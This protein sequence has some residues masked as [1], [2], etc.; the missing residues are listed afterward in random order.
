[1][2]A[3]FPPSPRDGCANSILLPSRS[4]PRAKSKLLMYV[5]AVL[6]LYD[7][8]LVAVGRCDSQC[9]WGSLSSGVYTQTRR[10]ACRNH[11]R[12]HVRLGWD[13]TRPLPRSKMPTPIT[14]RYCM[15]VML[16]LCSVQNCAGSNHVTSLLDILSLDR[17]Y[18]LN[19][20]CSAYRH[21]LGTP[22]THLILR[23]KSL[24]STRKKRY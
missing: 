7:S 13:P 23:L 6:R 20:L 24:Y 15:C 2:V 4:N 10:R 1:M 5:A 14:I 3:S 19:S 12:E 11:G 21:G 18:R 16:S 9:R 8:M 22:A 17:S